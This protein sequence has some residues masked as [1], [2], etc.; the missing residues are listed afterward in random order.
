MGSL[1]AKFDNTLC[2]VCGELI[3]KGSNI[4]PYR[5]ESGNNLSG[6]IHFSCKGK[7]PESLEEPSVET[8]V[9]KSDEIK[10]IIKLKEKYLIEP[11]SIS[12]FIGGVNFQMDSE[13]MCRFIAYVE[14][15]HPYLSGKLK[16]DPK[17][18]KFSQV[19]QETNTYLIMGLK[20]DVVFNA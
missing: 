12:E 19:M 5:D 11:E 4:L 16:L 20:D 3:K 15:H 13:A 7:I 6:F 10:P 14:S 18:K 1:K 2:E 17:G 9:I 8:V